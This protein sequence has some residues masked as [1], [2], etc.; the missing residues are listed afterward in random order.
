[1][2]SQLLDVTAKHAAAHSQPGGIPAQGLPITH[3][4]SRADT[5]R[6]L[7]TVAQGE[8]SVRRPSPHPLDDA[9]DELVTA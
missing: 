1:M 8:P 9:V 3:D 4:R 7:T 6:V 2:D 5:V